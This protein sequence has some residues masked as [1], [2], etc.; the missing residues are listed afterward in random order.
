[1]RP[2]LL[3]FFLFNFLLVFSQE[4][5]KTHSFVDANYYKGFISLHNNDI[6]HLITDRPD[7][8]VLSWN[9]K[10]FGDKEWEHQYGYP[11]YG[12]SFTYMNL[13]NTALGENYSLGVHYNFYFFN[14]LLMFRLSQGVAYVTKPYDRI[15]NPKGISFGSKYVSNSSMFLNLKKERLFGRFGLQGGL[16][17]IH[18][19]N[20]NF[21]EPNGSV[22]LFSI[23]LGLTYNLNA[24]DRDFI[25]SKL[26]E[27]ITEPVKFNF[28]FSS[29]VNHGETVGSGQSPFY[30]VAA[31]ADKRLSRVSG[32]HLGAEIFFSNYMK[33]L[34]AYN[35]AAY[36][37]LNE[38]GTADYKRVGLF[39]GHEL[40][41]NKLS[42]IGQIGYYVY[43]PYDYT[44]RTYFRVGLKRYFHKKWFAAINL[45]THSFSA[46]AVEFGFGLRI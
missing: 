12:A 30:I 29:G 23:N 45:K 15:D 7:G 35:A 36:P 13:K 6:L 20:A 14:R 44:G 17:Y 18:Y 1:M 5:V 8:V 37:E 11:D 16:A 22:N 40:F 31:Y 24:E 25:D 26:K 10:T 43:Y 41:V 3:S 34:I 9:K 46:E 39:V 19:S 33:E 38:D 4:K 42:F 27:K 28:L 32:I 2:L 21:K